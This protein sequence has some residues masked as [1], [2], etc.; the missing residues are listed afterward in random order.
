MGLYLL[1][2]VAVA[3]VS[4]MA[5]KFYGSVEIDEDAKEPYRHSLFD[6]NLDRVKR[7]RARAK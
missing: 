3:I 6:R 1:G 7:P 2:L 4:F 5:G